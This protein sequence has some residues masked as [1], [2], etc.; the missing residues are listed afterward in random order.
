MQ[1]KVDADGRWAYYQDDNRRVREDVVG[2]V[3]A[4]VVSAVCVVYLDKASIKR[5]I[6]VW[7]EQIVGINLPNG[8][9]T[10][11]TTTNNTTD[12]TTIIITN[13][14]TTI[15]TNTILTVI[16]IG[17]LLYS[18]AVVFRT[19]ARVGG[20]AT[21]RG[22]GDGV[23]VV[24]GVG[25]SLMTSRRHPNG[26]VKFVPWGVILRAVK[27]EI[28][29]GC[30]VCEQVYLVCLEDNNNVKF[31]LSN[32]CNAAAVAAQQNACCGGATLIPIVGGEELQERVHNFVNTC[33]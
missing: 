9:N 14:T 6:G 23:L 10:T 26:G 12:T 3:V 15:D 31:L 30:R 29:Q 17:T 1:E 28:F 24:R 22:G 33:L 2:I 27:V 7:I 16:G 5:V 32:P 20:G 21:A 19:V 13:T 18:L 4:I 11:N 8:T 25:V